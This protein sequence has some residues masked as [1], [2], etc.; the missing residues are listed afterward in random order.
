MWLS[1]DSLT[2]GGLRII[3][4]GGVVA[5][6]GLLFRGYGYYSRGRDIDWLTFTE[7][8]RQRGRVME[9]T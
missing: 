3:W 6:V 1:T 2:G 5:G 4:W 9:A 7:G 8:R